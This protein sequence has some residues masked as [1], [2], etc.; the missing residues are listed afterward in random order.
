MLYNSSLR[1][2]CVIFS[3]FWLRLCF[4]NVH[5]SI[6]NARAYASGGVR[7]LKLVA[8]CMRAAKALVQCKV[9]KLVGS[10]KSIFIYEKYT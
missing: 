1:L 10:K 9:T 7:C 3:A 2:M 5:Q 8:L 6:L 4:P